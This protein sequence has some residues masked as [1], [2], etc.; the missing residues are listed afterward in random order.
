MSSRTLA[1]VLLA[2]TSVSVS[3]ALC[4]AILLPALGALPLREQEVPPFWS[5]L[6]PTAAWLVC[7]AL[8]AWRRRPHRLPHLAAER[9]ADLP[10]QTMTLFSGV[11]M[12]GILLG[13]FLEPH[14]LHQQRPAVTLICGPALALAHAMV[15]RFLVQAPLMSEVARTLARAG[16]H[17]GSRERPGGLAALG[18]LPLRPTV[19]ITTLTLSAAALALIGVHAYS[20]VQSDRGVA[21]D[22][23]VVDLLTVVEAQLGALPGRDHL[24]FIEGY[25]VSTVAMPLLLDEQN[26][27]LTSALG[28]RPGAALELRGRHCLGPRGLHFRCAVSRRPA[29][30]PAVLH[31]VEEEVTPVAVAGFR[32]NLLELSAGLLLFAVLL[33]LAIG[34]DTARDFRTMTAQIKAMAHQDELDLG[35]PIPVTSID[36]VG[37]LTAEIGRLRLRLESEL[38]EYRRSLRKVRE[39][40]RI[41]NRFF[42]DVSHELRTPLTT[43][44]GYSQMLAEGIAGETTEAQREDL[45]II[46]QSGCQLLSLVND[47]LDISVI[48]S[49]HLTLSL[50]S[51][52]LAGLCR[53]IVRGQAAVVRKKVD[54]TGKPIELKLEAEPELPPIVGDPMRLRRV[55]QN[56]L[57]NAIKFTAQGSIV[58]R[59]GRHDEARHFVS[60]ADTGVGIGAAELPLIFE[61]YRQVGALAARKQGTGLGLGICKHLVE[62]HE[63]EIIVESE[64]D[65]GTTFTVLLPLA[66]PGHTPEAPA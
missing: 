60:V 19:A 57:S 10:A 17:G 56:L 49:G 32:T 3:L 61:R 43:I 41:K 20:R 6:A 4:L 1:I 48:Q 27:A 2:L 45:R 16:G 36:E 21:A 64:V 13:A 8:A 31:P 12:A 22:R 47:V 44:C 38:E 66:G 33:G 5:Y 54:D 50:E 35:Q 7:A 55:V 23:H 29:P 53:D 26:R 51:T 14:P 52:D 11:A 40:D 28:I 9:L 24:R 62:L 65:R 18:V 42:S 46:Y 37:D 34:G 25:P 63:G 15:L 30:R 58:V 39:A 59:V